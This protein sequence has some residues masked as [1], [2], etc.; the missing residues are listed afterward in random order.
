MV[1][2]DFATTSGPGSVYAGF[3]PLNG[4]HA[5]SLKPGYQYAQTITNSTVCTNLNYTLYSNQSQEQLFLTVEDTTQNE[6]TE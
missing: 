2:A 5:P 4:P 3:M 6:A 1:G